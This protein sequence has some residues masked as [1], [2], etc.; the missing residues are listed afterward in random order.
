[1]NWK[2]VFYAVFVFIIALGATL[3]GAV[4]G[5][6][7]VYRAMSQQQTSSLPIASPE[8]E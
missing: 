7:A 2:K 6:V 8:I 1:M 3:T 4:A 5:G